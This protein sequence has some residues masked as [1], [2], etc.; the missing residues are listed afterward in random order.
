MDWLMQPWPWYVSGALI[1]LMVPLLYWLSGKEFG[2]SRSFHHLNSACSPNS[3]LSYLKENNWKDESWSL[4]LVAGVALGA[5]IAAQFM[6][7]EPTKFLPDAY[8]SSTGGLK[9]LVG[10]IL[11]GFGTRYARGCTSGH[12]I[13]GLS[14]LS[15]TSLIATISFFAG[16]LISIF[17]IG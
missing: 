11:I 17:V 10:G 6:S 2:M 7:A 3:K 16:G 1:G 5:F 9:L 8:Y 14:N 15:V 4:I 13:R 12:T